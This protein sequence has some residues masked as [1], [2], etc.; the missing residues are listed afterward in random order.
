[1]DTKEFGKWIKT[2]LVDLYF[3]DFE[4]AET[5]KFWYASLF[6]I[7]RSIYLILCSRNTIIGASIMISLI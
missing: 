3:F 6:E 5:F 1:M 7:F 4:N 2:F